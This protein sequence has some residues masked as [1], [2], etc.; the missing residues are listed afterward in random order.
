M[1]TKRLLKSMITLT[2]G[3]GLACILLLITAC[4]VVI[5]PAFAWAIGMDFRSQEFGIGFLIYYIALL[6][7]GFLGL[8]YMDEED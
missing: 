1:S 3:I 6:F 7:A 4:V 8:I 2:K 5:Y